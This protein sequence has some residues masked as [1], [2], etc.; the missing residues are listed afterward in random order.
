MY[1]KSSQYGIEATIYTA[2]LTTLVFPNFMNHE[3]QGITGNMN[4]YCKANHE[5]IPPL[6][7]E[8]ATPYSFLFF[9]TKSTVIFIPVYKIEL[10]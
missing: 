9:R 8:L 2:L 10:I 5:M 1:C 7:T 6:L 3:Y 4:T